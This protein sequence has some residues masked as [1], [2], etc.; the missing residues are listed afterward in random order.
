VFSALYKRY[1]KEGTYEE[2]SKEALTAGVQELVRRGGTPVLLLTATPMQNSLAELWGLVQYVE[3]TGTLLGRLPTFRE[4]FCDGSD[5]TLLSE[6]ASELRRRLQTVLQRKLRR[7]DME[8]LEVPYVERRARVFEYSMSPD[9][10]SLYDD[11]TAWLMRED[12]CAFPGGARQLLLIGFHRRMASSLSAFSASLQRVAMRL[13]SQLER[14][15]YDDQGDKALAVEFSQDLEDDD[16]ELTNVGA[17]RAP[18]PPAIERIRAEL[19]V[20]DGFAARAAALPDDSKARCFLDALRI[21]RER[22]D[23]GEGTGKAV[24]FT[25]SLTTQEYLRKLLL[26]NG[27]ESNDITLFRGDNDTPEAVAALAHWQEEVGRAIP[28][29]HLPSRDVALRLALVHEFAERSRVFISTEAG[30]KGLNLQFCE[31]VINYDLPWNPQRIEQ[32]IGRVH[33]YGQRRGV[34]VVSFVDKGNEAQR[35]TFE[36]LSRKLDLFGQVL[37]VS[38]AVLHEPSLSAP[39]SLIAGIASDF[40]TQ[41]RRIYQQARSIDDVTH[42]L[43]ELRSAMEAKRREFDEEQNRASELVEA[44][45]DDSIRHVFRNYQSSLPAELVGLDE[46]MDRLI[47]GFLEAT[48]VKYERT[49]RHGRV[50]YWMGPSPRLPEGYREGASVVIGDSR[51]LSDGD[52]VHLGH[53]LVRAAIEEAREVTTTRLGVEFVPLNGHLPEALAPLSGCRGRLVVTKVSYRGIE[54]VDHLLSTV[55]LKGTDEPLEAPTVDAL[56]GLEVSLVSPSAESDTW[57]GLRDAVSDAVFGDQSTVAAHEQTRFQQMLQQ[58]DRYV[59]DQILVIRRRRSTLEERV[60]EAE[61][62]RDKSLSQPSR[63]REDEILASL[64]KDIQRTDRQIA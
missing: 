44:R 49:P 9:E 57:E 23:R 53:P 8:F 20:V 45:L 47:R 38:D 31:T 40:E 7:H 11:V 48:A 50:E 2:D 3:P 36:I 35:L 41:L 43:R 59:D 24:V 56:L 39:E 14:R 64:R 33:R 52:L 6:Q 19:K 18:V 60:E 17:E 29:S 51:D 34:T 25:E 42:E 15:G 62:R 30:A 37:D 58:L 27:Y 4:V 21:I 5:R 13:R 28:P 22:A 61:R 10:K 55:T 54:P 26:K 32:R 12:L 16:S 1:D 46:D 63:A